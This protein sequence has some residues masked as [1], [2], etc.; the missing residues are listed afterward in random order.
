MLSR[1]VG[2]EDISSGELTLDGRS[3]K[4]AHPKDR[5]MAMVFQSCARTLPFRSNSPAC[6][7]RRVRG[8]PGEHKMLKIHIHSTQM[9][10]IITVA[11]SQWSTLTGLVR[12]WWLHKAER[13]PA[14]RHADDYQALRLDLRAAASRRTGNNPLDR[15]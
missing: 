7:N 15:W 5:N 10:H 11:A 3:L 13:W 12:W 6:R 1:I 4:G 8:V 14:P 2:L 9:A